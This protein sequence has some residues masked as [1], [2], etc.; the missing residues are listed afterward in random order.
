MAMVLQRAWM[1][2]DLTTFVT[3]VATHAIRCDGKGTQ[4][5]VMHHMAMDVV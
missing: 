5:V 1:F 4:F 3:G 2:E